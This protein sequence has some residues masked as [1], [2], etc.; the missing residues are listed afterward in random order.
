ML[1]LKEKDKEGADWEAAYVVDFH[2]HMGKNPS[3]KNL[4]PTAPDGTYSFLREILFGNQWKAGFF[5][6]VQDDPDKFKFDVPLEMNDATIPLLPVKEILERAKTVSDT[7]TAGLDNSFS[8]DQVIAFPMDDTY[9][10]K[11]IEHYKKMNE[12]TP[13][14]A[15]SN[16]RLSQ[17]VLRF[18]NSLRVI[19]FGRVF[20]DDK[21]AVVEVVRMV[22]ELNMRGLKLHPKSE[23]FDL[24]GERFRHIIRTC[25]RLQVPIILHTSTISD[26]RKIHES[27]NS[28]IKEK[29][30]RGKG[31]S[32][33]ALT[34]DILSV[35]V[36]LGHCGWH[37]SPELY[38]CLSHPNI[39]GEISGIRSEGVNKFF[40]ALERNFDM[41]HFYENTIPEIIGRKDKRSRLYKIYANHRDDT[42]S[43]KVMYGSDF[44]FMDHN[45]S[46]DVFISLFS[47]EFP[48][49]LKDIKKI[50]G[51]NALGILERRLPGSNREGETQIYRLQEVIDHTKLASEI[52]KQFRTGFDSLVFN[53]HL[54]SEGKMDWMCYDV[55]N[56]QGNF[57]NMCLGMDYPVSLLDGGTRYEISSLSMNPVFLPPPTT[58]DDAVKLSHKGINELVKLNEGRSSA[59]SVD[60][61]IS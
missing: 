36:V 59:A 44:P 24:D 22:E 61:D 6:A 38:E 16:S 30:K 49:E 7:V 20:P 52:M 40:S 19:G 2:H 45:Q 28:V 9:A 8:V 12:P 17:I 56:N 50:L 33:P 34:E 13:T 57:L 37:A 18:P 11:D 58:S 51:I 47:R 1:V 3:F 60:F 31:K 55:L 39:H 25:S 32:L 14:Y 27:V 42:W 43:S 35:R 41:N 4:S 10:D 54:N 46:I 15:L 29:L 5:K 26:V 48:G 53:P 23:A 21:N